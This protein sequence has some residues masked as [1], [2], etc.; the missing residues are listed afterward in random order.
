MLQMLDIEA[1]PEEEIALFKYLDTDGDG[2]VSFDEFLPWYNAAAEAAQTVSSN[3][4]QILISRRTVNQFDATPVD[5]DVLERAVECAIAAPNRSG[6]EPWRFIRVG[7]KTVQKL[8]DLKTK[9]HQEGMEEN[10]GPHAPFTKS[11]WTDIPGWCVVTTKITPDDPIVELEDFQST[12]CAV[13][14]L[15]V[16]KKKQRASYYMATVM[17]LSSRVFLLSP[18]TRFLT[19]KTLLCGIFCLLLPRLRLPIP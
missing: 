7:P 1:S 4:Q 3:F 6:S 13:Q 17:I 14:N 15:M 11:Q 18:L 5:D 19:P 16:R 9:F 2:Q 12:S 10:R 8:Q